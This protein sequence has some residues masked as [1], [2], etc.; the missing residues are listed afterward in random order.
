MSESVSKAKATLL[1]ALDQLERAEGDLGT[2]PERVD[3]IVV[4]SIG[5]DDT[6]DGAWQEVGG[7]SSTPGPKWLHAAL[8]DRCARS[9]R[10][11]SEP[12]AQDDEDDDAG[13][14]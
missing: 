5:Y 11:A 13:E 10:E 9:F 6:G 1:R 2:E 7:W 14:P 4:Y 3:L 12:Y 8:L